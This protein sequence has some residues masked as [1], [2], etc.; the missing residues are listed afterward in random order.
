MVQDFQD[1]DISLNSYCIAS[2]AYVVVSPAPAGPSVD[3]PPFSLHP[4]YFSSTLS[5]AFAGKGGGGTRRGSFRRGGASTPGSSWRSRRSFFFGVG[6]ALAINVAQ[7]LWS[8]IHFCRSK[9]TARPQILTAWVRHGGHRC[10]QI[11]CP[12]SSPSKNPMAHSSAASPRFTP[13]PGSE[14]K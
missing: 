8:A 9:T 10:H 3:Y 11:F 5:T 6:P 1:H 2:P 4:G 12:P 7:H 14:I 13:C